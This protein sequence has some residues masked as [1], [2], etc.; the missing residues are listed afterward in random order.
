MSTDRWVDL[1]QLGS[2]KAD[3]H[4]GPQPSAALF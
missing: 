3:N 1:G 2:G 4:G